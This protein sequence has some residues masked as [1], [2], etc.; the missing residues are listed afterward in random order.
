MKPISTLATVALLANAVFEIGAGVLILFSPASVFP[1]AGPHAA[2]I[3]RTLACTA[4]SAGGLGLVLLLARENGRAFRAA[5]AAIGVFHLVVAVGHGA[6]VLQDFTV[7]AAPIFH[8]A[9]ALLFGVA[10]L[11]GRT[12][13]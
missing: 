13:R 12:K 3:G 1:G 10:W 5:F 4:I 8:G 9:L 11:A 6:A 7:P 2:A